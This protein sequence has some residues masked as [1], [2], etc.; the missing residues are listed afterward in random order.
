MK[1]NAAIL[2]AA[3]L[4]VVT[5]VPSTASAAAPPPQGP[6]WVILTFKDGNLTSSFTATSLLNVSVYAPKTISAGS[7][8]S[9]VLYSQAQKAEMVR[10]TLGYFGSGN[11]TNKAYNTSINLGAFNS[12]IRGDTILIQI[13]NSANVV[14]ASSAVSVAVDVAALLDQQKQFFLG[15]IN[16]NDARYA[17]LFWQLS[18]T[19]ELQGR[20]LLMLAIIVAILYAYSTR[21]YW[22][23]KR[24]RTE[25]AKSANEF[26]TFVIQIAEDVTRR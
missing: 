18:Q 2:M 23:T 20:Y 9:L 11:Q 21:E 4:L 6:N 14:E 15:I 24:K 17:N 26:E 13:Q 5:L 22:L 8:R 16:A 19:I 3:L 25:E 10:Y 12:L 1:V 7:V